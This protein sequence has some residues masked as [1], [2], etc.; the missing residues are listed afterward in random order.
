M[1]TVRFDAGSF[2]FEWDAAKAVVNRRKHGVSFEEAATV[3]L[4]PM[5]RVFDDPDSKSTLNRWRE[6]RGFAQRVF[7]SSFPSGLGSWNSMDVSLLGA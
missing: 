5:A 2:S 6:A 3:F 7:F 4:D 1:T